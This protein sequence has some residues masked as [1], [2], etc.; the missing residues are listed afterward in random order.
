MNWT[1]LSLALYKKYDNIAIKLINSG[2][3][4]N[5][6]TG[7]G[8][9][10]LTYA[11]NNGKE[12]IISLMVE[13]GVEVNA[14]NQHDN[15]IPITWACKSC[16]QE[17]TIIMIEQGADLN[18]KETLYPFMTPFDHIIQNKSNMKKVIEYINFATKS[19]LLETINQESIISKSFINPIADLNVIDIIEAYFDLL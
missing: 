17:A 4:V 18:I 7:H 6:K 5:L 9:A 2:A 1:P 13:K 8:W 12:N 16:W 11:C 14:K 15:S 3:D 10:P 19:K